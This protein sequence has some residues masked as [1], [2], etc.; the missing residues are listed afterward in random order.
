MSQSL[1]MNLELR[2]NLEQRSGQKAQ[3]TQDEKPVFQ[4][5]R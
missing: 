4:K 3:K 2:S 1:K 5:H